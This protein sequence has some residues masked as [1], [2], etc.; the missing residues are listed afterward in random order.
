[1]YS[2]FR[3]WGLPVPAHET[4]CALD[5]G[6]D[7]QEHPSFG[8]IGI[9][10]VSNGGLN[11]GAVLVGSP[12]R[13]PTS[14]RLRVFHAERLRSHSAERYHQTSNLPLLEVE[15][16][17]TQFAR[18]ITSGNMGS[19]EVCT[20]KR[21]QTGKSEAVAE[22]P[23]EDLSHEFHADIKQDVKEAVGKIADLEKRL[24]ALFAEKKSLGV[25]DREE[26]LREVAQCKMHVEQNMPFVLHQFQEHIEKQTDAAK[27]EIDAFL[28]QRAISLGM[29]AL[30]TGE[31]PTLVLPDKTKS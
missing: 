5:D 1:M 29:S 13:H 19:G 2:S 28:K 15:M 24:K 12:I 25:K 22:P 14:I 10:R 17:E 18:M 9:S 30:A 31:G 7:K 20:L 4:G 26:I 21:V 27:D 23:V 8:L 11:G 16:S 3:R 6:E